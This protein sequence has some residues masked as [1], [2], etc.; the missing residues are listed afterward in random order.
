M[1]KGCSGLEPWSFKQIKHVCDWGIECYSALGLVGRQV[2]VGVVV[3]AIENNIL[4]GTYIL[5]LRHQNGLGRWVEC[6]DSVAWETWLNL[7]LGVCP[8]AIKLGELV[9]SWRTICTRVES[10]LASVWPTAHT[11]TAESID[12]VNTAILWSR[13]AEIES[14]VDTVEAVIVEIS[15]LIAL[16]KSWGGK[17]DTKWDHR[18][19]WNWLHY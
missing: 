16:C 17:D 6:L 10:C 2:D 9:Q 13:W 8:A 3:H 7:A 11:C 1:S 5:D 4:A 15:L 19:K 14:S 18:R 12:R